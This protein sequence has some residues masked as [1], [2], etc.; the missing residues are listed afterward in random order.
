MLPEQALGN[1]PLRYLCED[2]TRLGLHTITGRLITL[3]GIKPIGMVQWMR[4]NF[5]LYGVVE[6]LTGD[7]FFYEFS[8]LDS[9][10][11]QHFLEMVSCHWSDSIVVMQMDKG[12]FHSARDLDWPENI[13]PIFQPAHS[14]ATFWG[15]DSPQKLA[16]ELNP[17]ER[18]WEHLKAQLQGINFPN[19]TQLRRR[20]SDILKDLTPELIASLTGWEFITNAV[21]SLSSH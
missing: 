7:S 1:K 20:L 13:I 14:Q 11:Y 5:Y 9:S 2:E 21:L 16:P 17:I 6:P 4:D 10:C 19:L 18:L 12:K 8:H 3:K 15:E